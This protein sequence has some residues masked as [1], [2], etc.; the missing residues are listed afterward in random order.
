MA[1]AGVRLRRALLAGVLAAGLCALAAAPAHANGGAETPPQPALKPLLLEPL[2]WE[3]ACT[4][5]HTRVEVPVG[6]MS[7]R[8]REV[9]RLSKT[10]D[11]GAWGPSG[12]LLLARAYETGDMGVPDPAEAARIYCLLLRHGGFTFGAHLLSRLH[13]RGAGVAFSPSLADHFARVALGWHGDAAFE[14]RGLAAFARR[15]VVPDDPSILARLDAAEAWRQ[16]VKALAP[17]ERFDVLRRFAPSGGGPRS[18]LLLHD[19]YWSVASAALDAGEIDI[20]MAYLDYAMARRATGFQVAQEL[21]EKTWFWLFL[22]R[23]AVDRKHA[24]PGPGG[25]GVP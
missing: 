12:L 9:W 2:V 19:E 22:Y 17:R 4:P 24:G 23:L 20:V 6:R 15:G 3:E 1:E 18:D 14:R 7:A 13:A 21:V 16:Q 11:P 5:A 8:M 25:A 10:A